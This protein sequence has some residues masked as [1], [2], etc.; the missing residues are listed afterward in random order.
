MK[1]S[2]S[3]VDN[4]KRNYVYGSTYKGIH[5]L[6]MEAH[7]GRELDVNEIVHHIDGNP[8]NNEI[9]NL[10]LVS[11][12]DHTRTHTI[13]RNKGIISLH[14][15]YC[16]VIFEKRLAQ[17]EFQVRRNPECKFFCCCRCQVKYFHAQRALKKMDNAGLEPAI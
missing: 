16:D 10:E 8:S 1:K 6:I 17:Y 11:R 7:L 14:C 2:P 3:N 9:S 15:N 5:R 4:Y 12:G 13:A